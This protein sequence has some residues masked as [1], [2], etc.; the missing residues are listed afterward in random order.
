MSIFL[1]S[2]EFF[3][4]WGV[5]YVRPARYPFICFLTSG[6]LFPRSVYSY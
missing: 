1:P 6:L 5:F 2:V 4:E 3:F